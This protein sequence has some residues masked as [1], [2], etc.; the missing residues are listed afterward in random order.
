MKRSYL[1]M[2]AACAALLAA[3]VACNKDKNGTDGSTDLTDTGKTLVGIW[4]NTDPDN[5]VQKLKLNAD[6]TGEILYSGFEHVYDYDML[7]KAE[8]GKLTF[9]VSTDLEAGRPIGYDYLVDDNGRLHIVITEN[10]IRIELT[11]SKIDGEWEY[12]VTNILAGN[13]ESDD[14]YDK[15]YLRVEDMEPFSSYAQAVYVI[16]EENQYLC[17]LRQDSEAKPIYILHKL[18]AI[19]SSSISFS[20]PVWEGNRL[21][22]TFEDSESKTPTLRTLKPMDRWPYKTFDELRDMNGKPEGDPDEDP[23]EE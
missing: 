6:G 22:V 12:C 9:E 23:D 13:W 7:W 15:F 4:E 5:V 11:F 17:V 8:D 10:G 14:S 3:A 19:E 20:N 16:S 21:K 18:T 1:L 2:I